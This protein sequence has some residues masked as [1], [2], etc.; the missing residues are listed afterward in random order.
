LV[1][2]QVPDKERKRTMSLR[3]NNFLFMKKQID[4][5]KKLLQLKYIEDEKK[6]AARLA[7]LQKEKED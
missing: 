5:K 1:Q 7:R 6:E 4:E 3:E 2:Y